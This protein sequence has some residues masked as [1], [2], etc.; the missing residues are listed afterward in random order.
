MPCNYDTARFLAGVFF[1]LLSRKTIHRKTDQNHLIF[2]PSSLR[3]S[4]FHLRP[5]P[6]PR[7]ARS[8]AASPAPRPPDRPRGTPARP[9]SC[10]RP[11]P[12][13]GRPRF[14]D[15]G[16]PDP[17]ARER[18]TPASQP[19]RKESQSVRMK[20]LKSFFYVVQYF[21]TGKT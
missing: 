13:R 1:S 7:P 10:P 19:E 12:W 2:T 15:G 18:R 6:P 11:R 14:R 8:P 16:S 3:R 17:G 9:P 20:H 5:R 21:F 4:F